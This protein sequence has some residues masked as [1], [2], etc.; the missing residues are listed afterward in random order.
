M[1]LKKISVLSAI[2][3]TIFLA[4]CPTTVTDPVTGMTASPSATMSP[5]TNMTAS[6]SMTADPSMSSSPMATMSP[7]MSMSP[8]P[9]ATMSPM[10]SASPS[11]TA[12]PTALPSSLLN[13]TPSPSSGFNTSELKFTAN[14]TSNQETP[15]LTTKAKG[16]ATL[17][18]NTADNVGTLNLTFQDLTGKHESTNIHGPAFRNVSASP[19]IG[20]P[21][22]QLNNFKINFTPDQVKYLKE[23]KLYI[24]IYTS[25]YTSGQIRGQLEMMSN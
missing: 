14:L 7:D 25:Y 3:G 12:S 8:S 9:T 10:M 23:G 24:N 4:G 16:T 22:G 13:P 17:T 5:D 20:L 15:S 1:K 11:M 18:L 21:L 19:I 2:L 6:P